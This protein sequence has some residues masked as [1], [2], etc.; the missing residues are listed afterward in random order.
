MSTPLRCAFLLILA[1]LQ[2]GA[3]AQAPY[4]AKPIRVVVPFAPGTAL[5][6][7]VRLMSEHFQRATGQP[8]VVENKGGAGGIIGNEIVA[9]AAPDGYTLGYTPINTLAFNPHLYRDLPYDPLRSF[10]YVTQVT[11]AN[12]VLA[13]SAGVPANT[14][15]EFVAWVKANPGTVNIV[16]NGAGT[17]PH[18]LAV[19][20]NQNAGTDLVPVHYKGGGEGLKDFLGGRV[21]AIFASPFQMMRHAA[22]GNAKILAIARGKRADVLPSVPTFVELGYPDMVVDLWTCYVAPAG[23]PSAIVQKLYTEFARVMSVPDFIKRMEADGYGLVA[24]T[25]AEMTDMARLELKRWGGV[26][27]ASGLKIQ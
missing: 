5:D 23:T 16:S 26:V 15:A 1:A 22:S 4:P 25:P 7:T 20:L 11:V 12:Q 8:L 2:T 3:S 9:K 14:L 13:V 10:A 24:N 17:T 21:Q 18:L 6:T 19:L 27:K